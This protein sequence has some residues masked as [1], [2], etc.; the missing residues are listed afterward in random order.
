[1]LPNE[2]KRRYFAKAAP[3]QLLPPNLGTLGQRPFTPQDS[4]AL[5]AWLAE[6]D[7]PRGTMDVAMLE[8]YLVA[9]LVWPVGISSGAWLPPIWGEKSGWRVPAKIAS[10][11]AFDKFIE[12]VVGLLRDLDSRLTDSPA[13]FVPTLLP[14]ERGRRWPRKTGVSWAHGFLRALQLSAQGLHGPSDTARSAVTSIARYGSFEVATSG[15][16][17]DVV[18]ANLTSAIVTLAS[19]RPSRGPLGAL[20]D[21]SDSLDFAS[22]AAARRHFRR[23]D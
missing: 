10:R 18:V 23:R 12:L 6:P 1:M 8:G 3:P 9:L 5:R 13:A 16:E 15:A 22:S 4:Q 19:E 14:D 20:K 21:T 7:W 11:E 2:L 17:F